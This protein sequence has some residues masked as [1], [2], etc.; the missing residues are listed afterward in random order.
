[1]EEERGGGGVGTGGLSLEKRLSRG[2]GGQDALPCRLSAPSCPPAIPSHPQATPT[3]LC[4]VPLGCLL[5]STSPHPSSALG[6]CRALLR[7]DSS[8]GFRLVCHAAAPPLVQSSVSPPLRTLPTAYFMYLSIFFP[9]HLHCVLLKVG[10]WGE[11]GSV[12]SS[13]S[14]I[15][16]KWF[17]ESIHGK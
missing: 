17:K 3:L 6:A 14:K 12:M 5:W 7:G 10:G 16:T 2:S 11:D 8:G 15:L 1:M 13:M 9:S 4:P